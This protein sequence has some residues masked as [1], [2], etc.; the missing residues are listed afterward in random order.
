MDIPRTPAPLRMSACA[1]HA[2]GMA[3]DAD[4]R[5]GT[6]FRA[7][8]A[9]LRTQVAAFDPDLV[10]M[11]GVDHVRTYEPIVPA[12][13]VV[14]AAEGLGDAGSP[15][16]S[17]DVDSDEAGALGAFLLTHDVDCTLTHR[18]ALD[19]GFGQ[20]FADVIGSLDAKPVIPVHINCADG[21]LMSC[22]RAVT[23][24]EV[25]GRFFAADP[26]RILFLATGGLSHAPPALEAGV[27]GM[28]EAERRRVNLEGSAAAAERI[29]P[30]WDRAFLDNLSRRPGADSDWVAVTGATLEADAGCGANEVRTWLAA[31]AAGDR[32]MATLAYE[33]VSEWMTGMG[34]ASS[35]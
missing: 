3:R 27:R 35:W 28:D 12:V 14:L 17:Y 24:G 5:Q 15:T 20:T 9:T 19:H 34:V 11:F 23:I 6:T 1:S 16:G 30:A 18:A 21:P 33:A 4:R 7:A 29:N 8:V 25:V 32:P 31:W 10:V 22:Q 2:P 13:S 26:R